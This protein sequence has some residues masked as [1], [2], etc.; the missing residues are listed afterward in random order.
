MRTV[1]DAM[2]CK[3]LTVLGDCIIDVGSKYGKICK[4]SDKKIV[5]IRSAIFDYDT[6]YLQT[7]AP[8]NY[9]NLIHVDKQV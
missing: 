9:P 7:N 5:G 6:I 1:V 8:E 2:T 4:M 3:A